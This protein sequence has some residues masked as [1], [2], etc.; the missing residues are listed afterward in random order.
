MGSK[1]GYRPT[2]MNGG[3]G[4]TS[5]GQPRNQRSR[6]ERGRE[7]AGELGSPHSAVHDTECSKKMLA[8]DD[9]DQEPPCGGFIHDSAGIVCVRNRQSGGA[10]VCAVIADHNGSSDRIVVRRA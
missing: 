10:A 9:K 4:I 8:F 6:I 2:S 1:Q 5:S 3:P 7:I